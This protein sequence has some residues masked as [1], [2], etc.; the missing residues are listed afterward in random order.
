MEVTVT[1]LVLGIAL[2][3]ATP[4]LPRAGADEHVEADLVRALSTS[5]A[6]AAEHGGEVALV[7]N[8]KRGSIQVRLRLTEAGGDSVVTWRRQVDAWEGS[9]FARSASDSLYIAR[10]DPLGRAHAPRLRWT[11]RRGRPRELTVNPWTGS[12]RREER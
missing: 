4:S 9:S 11:D 5:R 8:R 10:F 2:A 1:L 12:V 6:A 7:L 3:V